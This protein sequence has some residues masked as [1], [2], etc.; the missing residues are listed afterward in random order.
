MTWTIITKELFT[1][2]IMDI[3]TDIMKKIMIYNNN[4]MLLTGTVITK[5]ILTTLIMDIS[6]D[7]M[8]K[9]KTYSINEK[10]IISELLKETDIY[11]KMEIINK[12]VS[13]I[14]K[15]K[16][17]KIEDTAIE[18]CLKS[19]HDILNIIK[20]TLEELVESLEKYNNEWFKFYKNAEY[21]IINNKL[22]N[23]IELLEK[24]RDILISCLSLSIYNINYNKN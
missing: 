3:S 17:I 7:V 20:E 16:I 10:S 22:K 23:N 1:N 12:L 24:R 6:T 18:I 14:E 21:I 19:I 9:M 11:I 4:N 15:S 13:D 5:E 2:L 8:K